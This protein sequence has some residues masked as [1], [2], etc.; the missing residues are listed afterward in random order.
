MNLA[1]L[2]EDLLAQ[3]A[4]AIVVPI[5]GAVHAS[6]SV[7]RVL[8][9]VGRQLVRR[10]TEQDLLDQIES[11]LDLPLALGEAQAVECEGIPFRWLVLVS[12]LHHTGALDDRGKR[13]LVGR[14][15]S[16]A[17]SVAVRAGARTVATGVLQGGWRL[18]AL[19]AFS[20]MLTVLDERASLDALT[21]CC[22]DGALAEQL[23]E[24]AR[25]VGW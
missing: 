13:A 18:S 8:G 2:S 4:D 6:E 24:Q 14:A 20:A 15:C 12:T 11:Q 7:D 17:I 9:N 1:V 19:E 23:R 22:L 10:F 3:R 25:S 21:V 5:D 16:S